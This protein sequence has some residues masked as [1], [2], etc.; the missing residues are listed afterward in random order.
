MPRGL[1]GGCSL[2]QCDRIA[3]ALG[4]AIA[5]AGVPCRFVLVIHHVRGQD[6]AVMT[7]IV[8]DGEISL[9][10]PGLTLAVSDL[11]AALPA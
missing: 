9:A 3:R 7:R 8:R 10:P 4:A 11:F 1:D 5:Q 2:C 6:D